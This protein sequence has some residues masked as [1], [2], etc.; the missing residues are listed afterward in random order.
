MAYGR[1]VAINIIMLI[2]LLVI[3]A[4]AGVIFLKPFI[5]SI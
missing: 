1:E 5:E 4:I 3:L 2:I